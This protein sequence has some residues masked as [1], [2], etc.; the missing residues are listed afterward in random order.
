MVS[1]VCK[2]RSTLA[3]GVWIVG[4]SLVSGAMVA[5][6]GTQLSQA[7]HE[8]PPVRVEAT[9]DVWTLVA[10]VPE[11]GWQWSIEQTRPVFDRDLLYVAA[12]RPNPLFRYAQNPVTQRLRTPIPSFRPI[13][14]WVAVIGF[15]ADMDDAVYARALFSPPAT[16]ETD[17]QADPDAT[18]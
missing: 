12:R 3:R 5:C 14:V 7:P 10:E 6:G 13:E 9:G 2:A 8:G 16:T 18:R 1:L 11:S 17:A 4:L 15:D